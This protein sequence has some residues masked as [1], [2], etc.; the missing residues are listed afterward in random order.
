[1]IQEGRRKALSPLFFLSPLLS[2][3]P[4]SLTED[5]FKRRMRYIILINTHFFFISF[6]LP[7][8]TLL[9]RG[10]LEEKGKSTLPSPF[11]CRPRAGV[12]GP[13]FLSP[14]FLSRVAPVRGFS[15]A[16]VCARTSLFS[17]LFF[18]SSP[19]AFS[20]PG[21]YPVDGLGGF[22]PSPPLSFFSSPP[23]PRCRVNTR[24]GAD[25][26]VSFSFFFFS[27]FLL[28]EIF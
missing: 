14:F 11:S 16:R 12:I 15:G 28:R 22:P 2:R 26:R 5:R 19:L 3:L 18:F 6:T 10:L 25:S 24:Q 20:L 17:F 4:C 1:M 21:E 27:F 9:C 13:P 8:L 23:F 7:S